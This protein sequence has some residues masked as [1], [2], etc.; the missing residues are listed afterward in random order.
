MEVRVVA[1]VVAKP[2]FVKE[3]TDAMHQLIE[4]SRQ[5]L[6]CLQYDLHQD[7][8]HPETFIFYERWASQE[9]LSQHN[10]TEHL[11]GF[12]RFIEKKV[13]RLD[14]KRLKKIG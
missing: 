5:E 2:E 11:V 7:I 3:V 6:G 9:A 13:A 4:H 10:E 12:A 8:D 14:I 1:T